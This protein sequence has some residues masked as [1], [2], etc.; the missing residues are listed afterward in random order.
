MTCGKKQTQAEHVSSTHKSQRRLADGGVTW[1]PPF[2]PHH[3]HSLSPDTSDLCHLTCDASKWQGSRPAAKRCPGH[4]VWAVGTEVSDNFFSI[5]NING[6]FT[7]ITSWIIFL[8]FGHRFLSI[9]IKLHLEHSSI[10][11]KSNGKNPNNHIFK[12]VLNK[13]SW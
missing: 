10:A 8:Y 6:K 12:Q 5:D 3:P 4:S 11:A 9:M 13:F 2:A 1:H 7:F